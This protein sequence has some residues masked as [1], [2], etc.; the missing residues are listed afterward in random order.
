VS[1]F[2]PRW[3]GPPSFELSPEVQAI[4]AKDERK[5][6]AALEA[7]W[8]QREQEE[9]LAAEVRALSRRLAQLE[10]TP[11]RA[12]QNARKTGYELGLVIK[13]VG[14]A[15]DRTF[16]GTASH[17]EADLVGDEVIP[18]GARY[19][20]PMPLLM[21]HQQHQVVG[22]V[23]QAEIRRADIRVKARIATIAEPGPLKDLCD[24]AWLSVKHA[25][26]RSL[27]I[28]FFPI[29]STPIASGLRHEQWQWIET[30]LVSCPAN[31]RCTI[32]AG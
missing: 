3:Y 6:Q 17:V 32:G 14:A 8:R 31:L 10:R 21:H 23:V 18:A 24:S 26:V 22:S 5:R 28:G 29:K 15:E 19:S 25:L 2:V 7:A 27:S 4:L 12:R 30:S 13:S 20:L 11:E 9:G 1:R 16:E